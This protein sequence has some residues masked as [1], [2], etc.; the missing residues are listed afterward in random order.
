LPLYNC[1]NLQSF[2]PI[3][4]HYAE[5]TLSSTSSECLRK[6]HAG[7]SPR[8]VEMLHPSLFPLIGTLQHG[9]TYVKFLKSG[10][11]HE[12]S[13]GGLRTGSS[14]WSSKVTDDKDGFAAISLSI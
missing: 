6:L 5:R 13:S 4:G 14:H 11:A 9:C 2:R 12:E 3:R 10:A 7:R 8:H 1:R